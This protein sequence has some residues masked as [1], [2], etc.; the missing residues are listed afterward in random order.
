MIVNN[1]RG[2][3]PIFIMIINN[4]RKNNLSWSFL[5]SIYFIEDIS[6][7]GR[8]GSV[9]DFLLNYCIT[10]H[11]RDLSNC[12]SCGVGCVI[13]SI[14]AATTAC[15]LGRVLQAWVLLTRP[16]VWPYRLQVWQ[17]LKV[18]NTPIEIQV[19]DAGIKWVPHHSNLQ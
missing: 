19:I 6:S 4:S 2:T 16:P 15:F 8:P 9:L 13:V 7:R 17:V 14:T 10:I 18:R 12:C 3:I 11:M 5:V 1:S